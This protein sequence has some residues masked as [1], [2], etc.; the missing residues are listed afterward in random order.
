MLTLGVLVFWVG[1]VLAA[2]RYPSAYDWRYMTISSLLYPDRDPEGYRWAC[3]GLVLCALAGWWWVR[4]LRASSTGL[5]LGFVFMLA[6]VLWPS[7]R[8][9]LPRVHQALALMA[10]AGI[11]AGIVRRS[12]QTAHAQRSGTGPRP[13]SLAVFLCAVPLLPVALAALS[14]AYI[15]YA[16]PTLPWVGMSWR[17]YGIPVCLSFAFWEW[18]TCAAFSVYLLALSPLGTGR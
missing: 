4:A 11:S 10:F 7:Q 8:L 5:R 13:R 6:C 18:L 9:G 17:A 16:L 14:Q 2:R 12:W 15:A 3:S 1:L